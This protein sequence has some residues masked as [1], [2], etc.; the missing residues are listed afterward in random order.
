MFPDLSNQ[1]AKWN[2]I[3]TNRNEEQQKTQVV[4]ISESEYYVKC[5]YGIHPILYPI[6]SLM[7]TIK[8]LSKAF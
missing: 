1:R 6:R 8:A 4:I 7:Y 2:I 3:I 5:N